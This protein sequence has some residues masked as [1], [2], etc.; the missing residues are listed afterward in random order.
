MKLDGIRRALFY[1]AAFETAGQRAESHKA[2]RVCAA[3]RDRQRP[4]ECSHA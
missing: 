3:I 1:L 4:N 2:V